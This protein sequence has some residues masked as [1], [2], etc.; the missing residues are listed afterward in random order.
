MINS[1]MNNFFLRIQ[2]IRKINQ[3]GSANK[4]LMFMHFFLAL[5]I[6]IPFHVIELFFLYINSI[7]LSYCFRAPRVWT[8]NELYISAIFLENIPVVTFWTYII[9]KHCKVWVET[10]ERTYAKYHLYGERNWI[11][12]WFN[13]ICCVQYFCTHLG[14]FT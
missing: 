10:K 9:N 4:Y 11:A 7:W 6:S 2:N 3:Q 5:L 12:K 1:N 8:K 13:I 14:L